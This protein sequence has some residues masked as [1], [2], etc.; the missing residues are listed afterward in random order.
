MPLPRS[1][2]ATRAWPP[3][4]PTA[5][6]RPSRAAASASAA[7]TVDFPTPPFPVT[8][9]M[10]WLR[11]LIRAHY[12]GPSAMD[13]DLRPAYAACRRLQRR[14]APTSLLPTGLPPPALGAPHLPAVPPPPP[15]PGRGATEMR[16]GGGRGPTPQQ[17]LQRARP[18]GDAR[19]APRR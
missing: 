3:S 5:T 11:T 6:R 18:A 17:I 15:A 16:V 10:G 9:T 12:G 4:S 19:P 2:P 7:A 13:P 8:T 1:S 14:P